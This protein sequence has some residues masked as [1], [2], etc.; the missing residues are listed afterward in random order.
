MVYAKQCPG[1][2]MPKIEIKTKLLVLP[3]VLYISTKKNAN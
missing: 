1:I 2:S 3:L